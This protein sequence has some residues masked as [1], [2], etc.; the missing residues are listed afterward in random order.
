MTAMTNR[1]TILHTN[2][3]HG[4]DQGLARVATMIAWARANADHPVLYVDAGDVEDTSN[5]LSALTKGVAMHRLLN[6]AGCDAAAVGNGGL[7]RYGPWALETYANAARYPLVLANVVMPEG[8]LIPGVQATH[9]LLAGDVRIGVIGLTDPMKGYSRYYGL[10][11]LEIVPLVQQLAQDLRARGADLILVLSHLG[12][13]HE[14]EAVFNDQKLARASPDDI[15]LIIGAHTHHALEHGEHI[16]RVWVA[17]AGDF[18]RFLGRVELERRGDQWQVISCGLEAVTEDVPLAPAVVNELHCI[19]SEL[20]TWLSEP[21]CTLED[22]LNHEPAAECGAGNLVAD[23]LRDYWDA[24]IG[25][26]TGSIGFTSG[27]EAGVMTRGAM[28]ER[29]PSAANPGLVNLHGWQILNMLERGWDLEFAAER[30][31]AY[32]GAARGVMHVSNMTR[33]DGV[34]FVANEPLEPER[35]YSVAGTDGE[36]EGYAGYAEQGW[37]LEVRYNSRIIVHEVLE[38]YLIRQQVI[39]PENGRVQW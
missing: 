37:N 31:R 7:I 13:Q 38:A 19:E 32:R 24:E 30:P 12:W 9:M 35:L 27:L 39:R 16:G 36:F 14:N 11:S 3:I 25:L 23:A 15:D 6:A 21:L 26:A 18:A 22:A 28:I 10:K 34:W 29:V 2:D 20:E 8:E 5:R 33:R 4:R 1:I 17:Q